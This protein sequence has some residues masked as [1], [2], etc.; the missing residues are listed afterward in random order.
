MKLDEK[1]FGIF[2]SS[3]F[4]MG[5]KTAYCI[6]MPLEFIEDAMLELDMPVRPEIYDFY[7]EAMDIKGD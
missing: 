7:C 1:Y 2:I 6:S 3:N 4:E 5:I